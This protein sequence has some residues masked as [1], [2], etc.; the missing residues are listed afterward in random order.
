MLFCVILA[1]HAPNED[2]R[3]TKAKFFIRDEFL[4]GVGLY[5]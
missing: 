1:S 5:L 4:V 2:E 3:V